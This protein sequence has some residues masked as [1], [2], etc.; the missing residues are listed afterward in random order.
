MVAEDDRD[1]SELVSV[2]LTSHGFLVQACFD[3]TEAQTKIP[4]LKPD[5][6][7][8]DLWLP[9]I[10]GIKLTKKL[11]NS[12]QTKNIPVIIVSAQNALQKAVNKCNADDFLEKPFNL[13]D[14]VAIVKKYI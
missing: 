6:V 3:G 10:D 11:K 8:M 12:R 13:E 14:L 4:K 2:I 5:L 9:G 7:I 1:I